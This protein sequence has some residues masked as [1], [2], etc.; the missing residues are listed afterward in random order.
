MREFPFRWTPLYRAAAWPF[1]VHPGNAWLRVDDLELGIRFGPWALRTPRSNIA[2]VEVTGGYA[3][4]RTA[5]PAHL[6]LAD[7]GITFATNPEL[8]L[9]IRFEEPVPCIDPL[10]RIRHPGATVTVDDV[11]GLRALLAGGAP[12]PTS[13]GSGCPAGRAPA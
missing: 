2:G 3:V 12:R 1:G 13:R 8:G 7:R 5:G 11:D 6:S 4:V 9:C 10:G